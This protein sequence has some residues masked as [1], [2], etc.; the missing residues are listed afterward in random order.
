MKKAQEASAYMIYDPSNPSNH[1]LLMEKMRAWKQLPKKSKQAKIHENRSDFTLCGYSIFL[2]ILTLLK[3]NY[4]FWIW[5]LIISTFKQFAHYSILDALSS[6][7]LSCS[8]SSR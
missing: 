3:H 1:R 6:S 8:A 7:H 4:T 5:V 2:L